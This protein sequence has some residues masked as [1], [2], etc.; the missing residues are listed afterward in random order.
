[1]SEPSVSEGVCLCVRACV[2]MSQQAGEG[3]KKRSAGSSMP[4]CDSWKK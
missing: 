1:M 4:P 3:E 2:H